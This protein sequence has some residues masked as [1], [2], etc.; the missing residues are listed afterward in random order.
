MVN[1]RPLATQPGAGVTANTFDPSSTFPV[2]VPT[3][4][5][6]PTVLAGVGRKEAPSIPRQRGQTGRVGRDGVDLLVVGNGIAGFTAAVEARQ[7]APD[8]T[9]SLVT[10]QAHPTINTPA[11][12]QFGAGRLALEQLLAYPAGIER[13]MGI[14]VISLRAEQLDARRHELRLAG[15]RTLRYQRLLLAT[16]AQA[17]GLPDDCPGRDFD[18][19]VTLHTLADYQD[20]RRRLP[21]AAAV[22]VIGGGYHAAE[23][24]MLLRQRRLRV[25]WLIRGERLLAGQL[26]AGASQVVLEHIQRLGVQVRL[27]TEV[28][29]I[30]GRIGEVAGVV[31]SSDEFIPCQLVASCTG[32]R[33]AV[34][35]A[36]DS[37]LAAHARHGIRVNDRLESDVPGIFAAGAVA[38][39]TDPQTGQRA[40]RGQWYFAFQ[41]G[42]LAGASMMGAA[43]P[44]RATTSAL[45]SFWHATQVEG[46]GVLTVG[47]PLIAEREHPTYEV[48]ASGGAGWH[49]R[50]VLAGDRLVGYLAAGGQ[51]PAGLAIKCLIDEHIDVRP[52]ARQLLTRECDVRA[53]MTQHRLDALTRGEHAALEFTNEP[54]SSVRPGA[55]FQPAF[56]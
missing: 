43:L 37:G 25:T 23:T 34:E 39:V 9:I 12:K 49:R 51:P 28:A 3:V 52:I 38:A 8:A 17:V 5:R 48:H 13:E 46:L 19:V 24:A 56:G 42:R 33:P 55:H 29:G 14:E 1:D 15:G 2:R 21:S 20:L 36:R 27:A 22:V 45:G 26:D 40:A 54:A 4:G 31:T 30:V 11:L 18:G 7:H 53:F 41:Q 44:A 6:F 50:I 16:G 35:L 47:A 32:V 10:A